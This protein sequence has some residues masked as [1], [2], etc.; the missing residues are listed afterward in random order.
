MI[1]IARF[2]FEIR[3]ALGS[4]VAREQPILP[5]EVQGLRATQALQLEAVLLDPTLFDVLAEFCR[6]HVRVSLAELREE[7]LLVL[8][9]RSGKLTAPNAGVRTALT[10][11]R[12]L[13]HIG[14]SSTNV[15][16]CRPT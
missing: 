13:D 15:N 8:Q 3:Q 6:V 16:E 10:I 1:D 5:H 14:P 4:L 2:K 11:F 7:S 9:C 12:S